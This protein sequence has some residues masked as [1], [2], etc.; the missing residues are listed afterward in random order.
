MR[1]VN[2]TELRKN[3]SFLFSKV[4]EGETVIVHRHGKPIASI[5]PAVNINE[6]RN[7]S[8]KTAGIKLISSGKKISEAIIEEREN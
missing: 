7:Q 3:I 6:N 1:T 4:E 5:S 8:W 2:T